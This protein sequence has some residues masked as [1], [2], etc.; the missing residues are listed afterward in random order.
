MPVGTKR[1]R[2]FDEMMDSFVY[3]KLSDVDGN[4]VCVNS[5]AVDGADASIASD[6]N[7]GSSWA[8]PLA[9]VAGAL[10]RLGVLETDKNTNGRID[11]ILL[12]PEHT[13]TVNSETAMA[14][15]RA[16][17]RVVGI[18]TGD[19]RPLITIGTDAAA[20][21][22]PI[23]AAGIVFANVRLGIAFTSITAAIPITA[24]GVTLSHVQITEAASVM[25]D[26]MIT[27]SADADRCTIDDL[28]VIGSDTT[29][30]GA[31]IAIEAA[32][33]DVHISN[34]NVQNVDYAMGII[35]C[36]GEN[37]RMLVDGQNYL[38]NMHADDKLIV[39]TGNTATGFITNV[40]G[41]IG[42]AG[43]TAAQAM[44][45]AIT[46]GKC[47]MQNVAVAFADGQ[48]PVQ[49]AGG[50]GGTTNVTNN[51]EQ[52]QMGIAG[53]GT[54]YFV[55]SATGSATGSGF[56]WANALTTVALAEAKC[57]ADTGDI[58]NVAEGH[59]ETI[60][61]AVTYD[62]AGITIIGHGQGENKSEIKFNHANASLVIGAANIRIENMRFVSTIT[63]VTVGVN[64]GAF[65]DTQIVGCDFVTETAADDEFLSAITITGAAANSTVIK[66]NRFISD[67]AA[68]AAKAID[69]EGDASWVQ[70]KDNY[71]IGGYSEGGIVSNTGDVLTDCEI[72]GNYFSM[73]TAEKPAISL[74][75]ADTGEIAYNR[76]A[77][78]STSTSTAPIVGGACYVHD[79]RILGSVGRTFYVHSGTGGATAVASGMSRHD[80]VATVEA[81]TL[82]CRASVGDTIVCMRGHAET[83]DAADDVDLD[84][85]GLKLIGEG[86]GDDRPT[87]SINADTAAMFVV[88][89]AGCHVENILFTGDAAVASTNMPIL[90]TGAGCTLKDIGFLNVANTQV[91]V[92]DIQGNRCHI[93]G[94][95]FNGE[96][97][98][99]ADTA[100]VLNAAHDC[101]IEN[102]YFYGNFDLGAIECRTFLSS[103]IRVRRTQIWTEGSEDLCILD[104]I[105]SSTG[106]IGPDL[107]LVLQD[108]ASNIT[109]AITGATF[110]VM[111]PVYVVNAVNEKGLLINWG[112]SGD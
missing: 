111:D 45:V 30:T 18:G 74:I 16:R 106:I 72:T 87:F 62:V 50:G 2:F 25:A 44:N 23:S 91:D 94:M 54:Q 12:A 20:S 7:S 100:I 29:S 69:I 83:L 32:C 40:L 1:K 80:P 27:L 36:A 34:L 55:D 86:T 13:E 107:E 6:S 61:A 93:D 51:Y 96:A 71:I 104:T 81:A 73:T 53:P 59:S 38:H 99:G 88:A 9:T 33:N 67:A 5:Q 89:G 65:T 92:F 82:L 14:L 57:I 19:A 103:R 85:A 10:T 22:I 31:I 90:V 66:G 56:D 48:P 108:N 24:A 63:S 3:G 68:G 77:L 39:T 21:S 79:N 105:T 95:H 41:R 15:N 52:N 76:G 42:D 64:I 37:L 60:L 112:A 35:E 109:E 4:V 11:A 26:D 101:L 84:L 46:P 97:G 98:D 58:I 75:G 110:F 49:L 47:N 78:V 8:A 43:A 17:V 70:I 28:Q 102:S